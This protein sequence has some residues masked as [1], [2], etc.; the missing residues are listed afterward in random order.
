[1]SD[2]NLVLDKVRKELKK[3]LPSKKKILSHLLDLLKRDKYPSLSE[4]EFYDIVGE[5]YELN[6]HYN[7]NLKML[8]YPLYNDLKKKVKKLYGDDKMFEMG[9]YLSKNFGLFSAEHILNQIKE[10]FELTLPERLNSRELLS[11][12]ISSIFSDILSKEEY[13]HLSDSDFNFIVGETFNLNPELF[14]DSINR[15]LRKRLGEKKRLE[16]DKHILEN[17]VLNDKEHIM[18]ES[19]GDIEFLDLL[20]VKTSGGLKF[21]A[22]SRVPVLIRSGT[23]FLTNYRLIA[24]GILD[25][26]V[27][28]TPLRVITGFESDFRT[29]S[30]R[31][32]EAKRAILEFSPTYGY[33]FPIKNHLYLEKKKN[34]VSYLCIQ[35]NQ[36]KGVIINLTKESFQTKREEHKDII[37]KILSKDINNIKYTIKVLLEMELKSKW[38]SREIAAFLLNL[39][40][41][42]E[43]QYLTD[44][45]YKDIVETTYKMNPQDFMTNVYPRIGSIKTTSINPIKKDLIRLIENLYDETT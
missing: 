44:S 35:E 29:D 5:I 18:Y 36:F 2:I 3:G 19:Y 8:F 28:W 45:E 13:Q 12:K 17:Y 6:L 7:L 15:D 41:S 40:T 42:E 14:M 39:R 25:I 9:Q 38:K 4:N 11:L 10:E 30:E 16:L 26:K 31:K 34:G 27:K 21:I 43:Y 37:F 22:S 24:Q 32:Y 33:Q 1:M 20:M 23:I